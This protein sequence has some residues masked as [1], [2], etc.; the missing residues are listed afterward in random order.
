MSL[1]ID[2]VQAYWHY[3]YASVQKYKYLEYSVAFHTNVT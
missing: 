3:T 1:H 2:L